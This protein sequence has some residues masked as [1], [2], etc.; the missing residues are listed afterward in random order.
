MLLFHMETLDT[1]FYTM[2]NN[3]RNFV[4]PKV[5]HESIS[6]ITKKV[7]VLQRL[8]YKNHGAFKVS[9]YYEHTSPLKLLK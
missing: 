3:L 4:E 8:L 5:R 1:L 9:L 2:D 7:R 6:M